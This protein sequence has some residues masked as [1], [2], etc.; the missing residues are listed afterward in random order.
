[1]K[2]FPW[3]LILLKIKEN[4][5]NIPKRKSDEMD[6][7]KTP[8]VI[9]VIDDISDFE[10]V[11]NV[12]IELCIDDTGDN[13]PEKCVNHTE[14]VNKPFHSIEKRQESCSQNIGVNK[15]D[16]IFSKV[17][18]KQSRAASDLLIGKT[19]DN[20]IILFCTYRKKFEVLLGGDRSYLKYNKVVTEDFQDVR[21]TRLMSD[22]IQDGMD[23]MINFVFNKDCKNC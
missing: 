20:R 21:Q 6:I 10:T 22:E 23:K 9:S 14:C 5:S 13:L 19:Q 15:F 18:L 1:M 16:N 17:V 7:D 8:V 2:L 12:H 11:E 4:I 3:I